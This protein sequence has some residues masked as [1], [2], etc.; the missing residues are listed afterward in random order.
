MPN[1]QGQCSYRLAEEEDGEKEGEEE[2]AEEETLVDCLL[3]ITP[4]PD[5]TP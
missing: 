4:L 5:R 1:F 3:S 2:E